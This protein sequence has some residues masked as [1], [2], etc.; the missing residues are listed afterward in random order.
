MPHYLFSN[1]FRNSEL[2][3]RIKWAA[4][5]VHNGKELKSIENKSDN[6]NAATLA[7]YFNLFAS[8]QTLEI[9][10]KEPIEVIKNFVLK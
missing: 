1:D 10:T 8:T 5:L 4:D 7:F 6:N 3:N 9:A 2:S